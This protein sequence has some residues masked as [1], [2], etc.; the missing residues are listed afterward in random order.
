MMTAKR[1]EHPD[2][3]AM[4]P[5]THHELDKRIHGLA[6]E[7]TAGDNRGG[8]GSDPRWISAGEL[9]RRMQPFVCRN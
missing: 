9:V 3:T 4:R 2:R 1:N 7:L 6:D 5:L 8:D